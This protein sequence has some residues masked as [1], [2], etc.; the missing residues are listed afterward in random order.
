MGATAGRT[1]LQGEGLQHQDGH[2]LLYASS[3]P[4]CEAYDPSFAYELA[5][6]IRDGLHRMYGND[7]D[8]FYYLTLYN[9]N[10]PMPAIPDGV[11]DGVIEGLYRWREA[12]TEPTTR[13][14]VLF[15][16]AAWG[17]ADEA[18]RELGDHWDVGLELWS[19]T[20]YKRL[21]E[22]ALSAERWNRLHP[23]DPPRVPRVTELL[24]PAPGP[25]VAVT[26]FMKAVPDQVARWIP[27][28]FLPLGTDGFGRS[29]ARD[30]LRRHFEIDPGHIVVAVLSMLASQ[31]E[32]ET[33]RIDKAIAH[34]GIDPDTIDP[35]LA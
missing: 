12:P 32:V 24:E 31:G 18:S 23:S 4:A 34:Y 9:E 19:A 6:I 21:R 14:T 26:D 25:I 2:S 35:R 3:V 15:S 11:V 16:G 5:V 8:V 30:A 17:C 28:P 27:A 13:A 29:D 10:Y 33:D 22:D 7:E 20:S 1:T